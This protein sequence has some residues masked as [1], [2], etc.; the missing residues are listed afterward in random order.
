MTKYVHVLAFEFFGIVGAFPYNVHAIFANFSPGK[1]VQVL[2]K[3]WNR[4]L[5]KL[6][7]GNIRVP[8]NSF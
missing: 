8:V 4:P 5:N 7:A 3:S 6:C 2:E 1:P